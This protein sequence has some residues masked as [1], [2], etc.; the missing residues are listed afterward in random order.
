MSNIKRNID[1]NAQT[2]ITYRRALNGSKF[3]KIICCREQY[4]KCH[5][6][7]VIKSYKI[8]FNIAIL[9]SFLHKFHI[10]NISYNIIATI[11]FM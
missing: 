1:V 3:N 2:R 7:F 9:D 11:Y 10:I 8:A 5:V 6:Y 4:Y